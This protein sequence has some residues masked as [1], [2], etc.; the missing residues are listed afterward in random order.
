MEEEN[1]EIEIIT[2]LE[3]D[4]EVDDEGY[5]VERG[6]VPPKERSP[7]GCKGDVDRQNKAWEYYVKSWREGKPNMIQAGVS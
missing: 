1:K 4:V 2:P 3:E 6:L 7:M 5:Y